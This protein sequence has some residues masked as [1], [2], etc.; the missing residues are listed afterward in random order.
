MKK[1]K[2]SK[3]VVSLMVTGIL[4][5]ITL[6]TNA[7]ILNVHAEENDNNIPQEVYE[8][9]KE[10]RE[11]EFP[12]N[13]SLE[14]V[15][16]TEALTEIN[17][18]GTEANN[19][20]RTFNGDLEMEVQ[21]GLGA[22]SGE[23]NTDPN[24][25][26]IVSNDTIMQ[27]VISGENE[28]RWYAF[29]LDKK[30]KVSI[31]LQMVE[32]LDADLYMFSLKEETATLELIG[33]SAT[34][35]SGVQEYFNAVM[36]PGTYFFSVT[37]YAGTGN[38]AFAYYESSIDVNYEVNDY[39]DSAAEV[40]LNTN[41]T[42]VIDNP[43]DWDY[44]KFTVSKPTI[45]RY[46]IS[47][48]NGYTLGYAGTTGSTPVIID[49]TLIKVQPGAYYFAVYSA[50]GTY[51]SSSTYTINFK[52]IGEYVDESIVPLRAIDETAG[53][54][55]Q[56]N[57]LGTD[58]Y[59]NGNPIDISYEYSYS[60]SNSEGIQS[61]NITLSKLD[62]VHCQIWNE[63]TQG[64][65]VVYYH[66]STKPYRNVGSKYLLRLMFYADEKVKFYRIMC[67][68]TGAYLENTLFLDPNYAIV[69]IDPDTGKLVD[70]TEFNYFYDF[71]AGSNSIT[72]SGRHDLTFNY[73]LYDYVN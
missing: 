49:G 33:G 40:S 43:G 10:I 29:V 26:Y 7:G 17:E 15:N 9:Q 19:M 39:V 14:I 41:I 67:R 58:C 23:E 20:A 63:E 62:G 35:G 57:L 45:L 69:L 16:E 42:G 50:D 48:T 59:V 68:G 34:E 73:S 1:M 37:G 53:I 38:F 5:F 47:T 24:Y 36:E 44:Y 4:I 61:Y 72:T 52:K 71:A 28:F 22:R 2:K 64:P 55:F 65:D 11:M 27:G 31:L 30:S 51:S 66:S 18:N 32:A 21:F 13:M 54:V 8:Q 46:S 56:T 25:A 60:A 70:I 6:F 3:R 12:Q